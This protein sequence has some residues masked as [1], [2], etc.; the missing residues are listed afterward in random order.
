MVYSVRLDRGAAAPSEPIPV[1]DPLDRAKQITKS[2]A[3]DDRLD[4]WAARMIAAADDFQKNK[5]ADPLN[6]FLVTH[7]R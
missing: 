6:G 3:G 2:F 7:L 1:A 5:R 4:T